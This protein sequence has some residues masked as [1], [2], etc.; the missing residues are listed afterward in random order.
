MKNAVIDRKYTSGYNGYGPKR[1][2]RYF[3]DRRIRMKLLI[4]EKIL[5]Y[6]KKNDMTQDQLAASVGVCAQ[7]VSGWERGCSYPDITLLPGI[8]HTLG[9]TIDELMGNDEGGVDEDIA[10]FYDCLWRVDPEEKLRM[11]TEYYHKYPDVFDLAD[12]L[13]MV[14]D[15]WGFADNAECRELMGEAAK[16]V[17]D[18]CTDT[19]IRYNIIEAMCRH[20]DGSELEHWLDMCPQTYSSIR[21][22]ALE[23]RLWKNGSTEEAKQAF[24]QTN[25]SLMLHF[26]ARE[27]HHM[28]DPYCSIEHNAYLMELIRSF[29]E[30]G[31]VPDGWMG[32]YAFISMRYAAG[33]FGAGRT[34]EGFAAFAQSM[35][36][37]ERLIALPD[38]VPLSLGCPAFF[39]GLSLIQHRMEGLLDDYVNS[40][41][42]K[43]T[44]R[45]GGY[46]V[47][48]AFYLY[49]MLSSHAGWEWFNGVREDTRFKEAVARAR[50]LCSEFEKKREQSTSL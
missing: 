28:G 24:C 22:E 13:V 49:N 6:R 23:E 33:L 50:E 37:Y 30:D 14:I 44:V 9:I 27:S 18:R 7:A 8:A 31:E 11:A 35:G 36:A 5:Q 3:I 16:R 42:E 40:R 17:I 46:Y 1:R 12:T 34:E 32:K 20:C 41:G 26:I 45:E 2:R 25:L 48:N 47:Q 19:R 21:S 39:G 4:G 29:G 43:V 38:G 10:A 15:Q